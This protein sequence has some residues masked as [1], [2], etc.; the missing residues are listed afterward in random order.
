MSN[1][2]DESREVGNEEVNTGYRVAPKQAAISTTSQVAFAAR[3]VRDRITFAVTEL[4]DRMQFSVS[5]QLDR[6]T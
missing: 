2:R 4:R 5:N 6:E 3:P 1:S